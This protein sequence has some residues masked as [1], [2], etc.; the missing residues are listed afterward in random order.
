[1]CSNQREV[2]SGTPWQADFTAVLAEPSDEGNL[3]GLLPR[4][5]YVNSSGVSELNLTTRERGAIGTAL[6]AALEMMSGGFAC[7]AAPQRNQAPDSFRTWRVLAK[8]YCAEATAGGRV[9]VEASSALDVTPRL[10]PVPL[11]CRDVG[12]QC[13]IGSPILV[14]I[15]VFLRMIRIFPLN[16]KEETNEKIG[17][18]CTEVTVKHIMTKDEDMALFVLLRNKKR[19]CVELCNTMFVERPIMPAI[20]LDLSSYYDDGYM[21]MFRFTKDGIMALTTHLRLPG[22]IITK[23]GGR[24]PAVEAVAMLRYIA[25]SVKLNAR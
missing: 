13:N 10:P 5:G 17:R 9:P 8:T 15:G 4:E 21:L 23:A 1:M 2:P 11:L 6:R 18:F 24:S 14:V 25:W 16:D 12:S 3:K 20:R 7:G 19:E 22:V